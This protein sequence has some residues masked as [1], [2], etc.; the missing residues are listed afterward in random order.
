MINHTFSRQATNLQI[1]EKILT[2]IYSRKRPVK[3]DKPTD[4]DKKCRFFCK[5]GEYVACYGSWTAAENQTSEVVDKY[6]SEQIK[7]LAHGQIIANINI[8]NVMNDFG[9]KRQPLPMTI[10]QVFSPNC[11]DQG[12]L[13]REAEGTKQLQVFHAPDENI[14][15]VINRLNDQIAHSKA[16]WRYLDKFRDTA[17]LAM[18]L[19][20]DSQYATD[21]D[22]E[23]PGKLTTPICDFQEKGLKPKLPDSEKR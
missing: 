15:D 2:D 7:I 14:D 18:R 9:G 1:V 23:Q 12:R 22:F 8:K 3:D 21:D 10:M 11:G 19:T 13:S 5:L 4:G 20:Q 16:E 17:S 6:A